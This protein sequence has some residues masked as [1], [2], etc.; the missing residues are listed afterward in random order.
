MAISVEIDQLVP[1]A[2][3]SIPIA[4]WLRVDRWFPLGARLGLG[5]DGVS[6]APVVREF[7]GPA[8]GVE[9]ADSSEF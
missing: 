8:R 4:R 3:V 7:E 1:K 2:S 6:L 5:V 9:G